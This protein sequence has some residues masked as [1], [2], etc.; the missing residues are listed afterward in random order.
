[1]LETPTTENLAM[2]VEGGTIMISNQ[3]KKEGFQI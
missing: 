3:R 1:M 2:I